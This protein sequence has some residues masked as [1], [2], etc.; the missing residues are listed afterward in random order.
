[1]HQ[2]TS[3]VAIDPIDGI[4]SDISLFLG[5]Y[6]LAEKIL[7]YSYSGLGL[8]LCQGSQGAKL[9]YEYCTV[10]TQKASNPPAI[11][12]P[13][14]KDIAWRR[15]IWININDNVFGDAKMSEG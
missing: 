13:K 2:T 14:G 4:F 15:Q 8:R 1:M 3:R 7:K 6:L 10:V 11:A 9:S 5:R 12:C